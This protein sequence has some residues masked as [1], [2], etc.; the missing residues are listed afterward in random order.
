MQRVLL[1]TLSFENTRIILTD[2]N[3]TQE[4]ILD[5]ELTATNAPNGF[6][7]LNHVYIND[8]SGA[9]LFTAN[10]VDNSGSGGVDINVDTNISGAR[11]RSRSSWYFSSP[12]YREDCWIPL[13]SP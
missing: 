5:D 8:T 3:T 4:F 2:R 1:I 9:L 13:H 6:N 7:Y 10:N 12:N 11:S